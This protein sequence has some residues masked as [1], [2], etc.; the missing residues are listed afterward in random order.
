M[1][2]PVTNEVSDESSACPPFNDTTQMWLFSGVLVFHA[3]PHMASRCYQSTEFNAP[4]SQL[5]I[6]QTIPKQPGAGRVRFQG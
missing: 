5:A 1:R 4:M 6:A 2:V 3:T